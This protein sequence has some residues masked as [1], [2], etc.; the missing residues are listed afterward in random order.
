M[1]LTLPDSE[2]VLLQQA[3]RACRGQAG[4]VPVTVLL[5]LDQ[6]HAAATVAQALGV[7]VSSVYRYAQTYQLHG[8]AGYL[9]A[10]QLGYWGLLTSATGGLVPGTGPTVAHRLPGHCRRVGRY[11]RGPLP[12]F[13]PDGPAAPVGIFL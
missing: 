9:R 7:D 11:L 13:G 12:G 3:Q 6:G 8:L 5:M 10:E 4:Y 2:R 1:E